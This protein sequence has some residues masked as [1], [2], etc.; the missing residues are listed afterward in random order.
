[1]RP[2]LAPTN[3]HTKKQQQQAFRATFATASPGKIEEGI[4][5]FARALAGLAGAPTAV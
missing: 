3:V 2:P 4:A 1:M 5:R